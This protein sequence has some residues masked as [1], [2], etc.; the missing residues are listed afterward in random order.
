MTNMGVKNA[1]KAAGVRLWE[2]ADQM[3]I[4]D[5]TLSKKLR[6]EL[7]AEEQEKMVAAIKEIAAARKE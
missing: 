2:L 5:T 7:P 3:G 1:A 4:A 6:Y